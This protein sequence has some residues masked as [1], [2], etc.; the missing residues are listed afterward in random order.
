M[1]DIVVVQKGRLS[2]SLGQIKKDPTQFS[3]TTCLR[4]Y[5]P[6]FTGLFS[7]STD[8]NPDALAG[9]R[10]LIV[11]DTTDTGSTLR[12]LANLVA[13]QAGSIVGYAILKT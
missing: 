4:Q 9:K 3:M 10:V 5:R 1:D 13:G 11:D 12:M 2:L 7:K 8:L 6:Y